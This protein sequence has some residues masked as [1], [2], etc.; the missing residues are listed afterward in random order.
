MLNKIIVRGARVHNLQNV[1]LDIAHNTLVVFT[2]L[3]GSG[4]SSLAFDTIYA[5]GQRRFMESL[6]SFTKQFMEHLDKPDVDQIDGLPPTIAIDQHTSVASPRST[7][8]TATEMYDYL[9]LLFA[10]TGTPHCPTCHKAIVRYSMQEIVEK[11]IEVVK[12]RPKETLFLAPL[13]QQDKVNLTKLTDELGR[14]GYNSVRVDKLT[15]TLREL[16]D[17]RINEQKTHDIEIV[18]DKLERGE[19]EYVDTQRVVRA[20]KNA[21]ELGDG[22]MSLLLPEEIGRAHV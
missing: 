18:V 8:G 22:T 6:S 3:S 5:E 14:L 10:R 4:K 12:T 21:M 20:I 15:Y 17:A 1:D 9:R 16:I 2:G 19:L 11:V 13:P 7:V